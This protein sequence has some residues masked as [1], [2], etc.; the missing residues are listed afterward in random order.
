MATATALLTSPEIYPALSLDRLMS[1]LREIRANTNLRTSRKAVAFALATYHNSDT[2]WTFPGITRLA[3]DTGLSRETVIAAYRDLEAEGHLEHIERYADL[4]RRQ[5][6]THQYVL[7]LRGTA[8]ATP[9]ND[10]GRGQEE[11]VGSADASPSVPPATPPRRF[12]RPKRL[13][14]LTTKPNVRMQRSLH[15]RQ[16]RPRSATSAWTGWRAGRSDSPTAKAGAWRRPATP[17]GVL[18]SGPASRP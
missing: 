14:L 12:S 5:R 4:A 1:W 10:R 6:L 15:R 13:N 17:S 16:Y 7:K 8:L 2:G 3:K 18:S 9:A 11:I